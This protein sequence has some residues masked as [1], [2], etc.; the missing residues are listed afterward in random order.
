M[1]NLNISVDP[2]NPKAISAT[3][4][5]LEEI[6]SDL[7]QFSSDCRLNGDT[8]RIP[9]LVGDIDQLLSQTRVLHG[10][11]SKQIHAMH[12]MDIETDRDGDR[13][14]GGDR[15]GDDTGSGSNSEDGGEYEEDPLNREEIAKLLLLT[16]KAYQAKHIDKEQKGHLKDEIVRRRSYLRKV[17]EQED[18]GNVLTTLATFARI[19]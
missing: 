5:N 17:V 7:V 14:G 15:H 13:N 4:T 9:T 12:R 6:I 19:P 16:S 10:H 18:F 3:K 8:D 2:S 11:I 1:G